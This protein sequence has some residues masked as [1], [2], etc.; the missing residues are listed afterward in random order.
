MAFRLLIHKNQLFSKTILIWNH[1]ENQRS[2]SPHSTN[3]KYSKSCFA[4]LIS[5]KLFLNCDSELL[6]K[7]FL[8]ALFLHFLTRQ[9][10]CSIIDLLS[11]PFHSASLNPY[12]T[13]CNLLQIQPYAM[14][15]LFSLTQLYPSLLKL[16]IL[17]AQSLWPRNSISM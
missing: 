17:K 9:I 8:F 6:R 2:T 1:T 5:T 4:L 7:L 13:L 10:F 11:L 3:K 12:Q 15:K 14:S 16:T